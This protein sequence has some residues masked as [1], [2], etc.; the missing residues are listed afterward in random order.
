[1]PS[2]LVRAKHQREH[3]ARGNGGN[4]SSVTA[5]AVHSSGASKVK[6]EGDAKLTVGTQDGP[7]S[8]RERSDEEERRGAVAL[9]GGR[10]RFDPVVLDFPGSNRCSMSTK[11]TRVELQ[12][13]RRGHGVARGYA[14]A[15]AAAIAALGL[16]KQRAAARDRGGRGARSRRG[17]RW[18]F[19]VDP[20]QQGIGGVEQR[21]RGGRRGAARQMRASCQRGRRETTAAGHRAL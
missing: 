10:D 20:E 4:W 16:E 11:T 17:G 14:I 19:V 21:S 18:G 15:E 7:V 5:I 8:A 13:T 3:G 12:D 6:G 1:M 9:T 2:P